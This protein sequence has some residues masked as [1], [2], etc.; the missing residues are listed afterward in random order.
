MQ[1]F[2]CYSFFTCFYAVFII[3]IKLYHDRRLKTTN[4]NAFN[5]KKRMSGGIGTSGTPS[6]LSSS[7]VEEDSELLGGIENY[8]ERLSSLR[9]MELEEE[10]KS[11][12]IRTNSISDVC[13]SQALGAKNVKNIPAASS[14]FNSARTPTTV[15][16]GIATLD[17]SGKKAFSSS[18]KNKS[19]PDGW[20]DKDTS[21]SEEDDEHEDVE[22]NSKKRKQNVAHTKTDNNRR[23][24]PNGERL[25]VPN[26][27]FLY[28]F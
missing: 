28:L 17:R 2:S 5:A 9:Q 23:R 4:K 6:S 15:F 21:D 8:H 27:W 3:G 26:L 13:G 19:A 16:G 20:A 14:G 18:H 10:A 1:H 7:E 22:E 11:E 24:V 25:F 12:L